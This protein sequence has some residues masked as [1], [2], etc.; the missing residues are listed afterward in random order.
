MIL[1]YRSHSHY[2]PVQKFNPVV[3]GQDSR[4]GELS[5]VDGEKTEAKIHRVKTPKPGQ[6]M[7]EKNAF[8]R[9]GLIPE[10]IADEVGALPEHDERLPTERG[11]PLLASGGDAAL[12]LG[13]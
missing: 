3:L 1:S 6:K 5:S 12:C 13:R 2:L 10:K 7:S 11:F 9:D 4:F 8:V